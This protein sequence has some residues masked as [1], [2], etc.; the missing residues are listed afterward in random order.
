MVNHGFYNGQKV[1]ISPVNL[2][3]NPPHLLSL[4]PYTPD[5]IEALCLDYEAQSLKDPYGWPKGDVNM[6]LRLG[7]SKA[8]LQNLRP[9]CGDWTLASLVLHKATHTP[10]VLDPTLMSLQDLFAKGIIEAEGYEA[11]A[12]LLPERKHT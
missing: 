3:Q 12:A 2:G 5:K 10:D 6:I 9:S 4:P 7:Y 1:N 11:S 8:G